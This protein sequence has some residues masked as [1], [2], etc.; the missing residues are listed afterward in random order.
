MR[1]RSFGEIS[2]LSPQKLVKET[3]DI[4]AKIRN[5]ILKIKHANINA[6]K[7]PMPPPLGI[8]PIWELLRLALSSK[9][10]QLPQ[11]ETA[12]APKLPRIKEMAK[13]NILLK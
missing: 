5:G 12:H 2:F 7:I 6:A 8:D 4:Q 9:P 11:L 3:I 10:R 13:R 1:R